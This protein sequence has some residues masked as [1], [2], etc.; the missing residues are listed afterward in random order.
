MKVIK[1]FVAVLFLLSVPWALWYNLTYDRYG[2]IDRPSPPVFIQIVTVDAGV[3][4][5]T[6]KTK[7][8]EYATRNHGVRI[9]YYQCRRSKLV[10]RSLIFV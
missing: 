10:C 8:A 9:L 1:T 6:L 3:F 7:A 4:N 2:S 5:N